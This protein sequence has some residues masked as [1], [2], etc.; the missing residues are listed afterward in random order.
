MIKKNKTNNSYLSVVSPSSAHLCARS[1]TLS[2]LCGEGLFPPSF[3]AYGEERDAASRPRPL[4]RTA[5][6]RV[7]L[8]VRG[9]TL[10]LLVGS[11]FRIG[12][13]RLSFY[14]GDLRPAVARSGLD[15]DL[16][17]VLLR[18]GEGF[19]QG[20]EGACVRL[21]RDALD[22]VAV[23]RFGAE[24]Q[25]GGVPAPRAGDAVDRTVGEL[26][27]E[28]DRGSTSKRPSKVKFQ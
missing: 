8:P 5:V 12:E 7:V 24:P 6:L 26:S 19:P 1:G 16:D 18:L 28:L 20:L 9:C 13:D 10:P 3:G 15:D 27:D 22:G 17:A 2:G 25:G 4:F 23:G 11:L 14:D 21:P